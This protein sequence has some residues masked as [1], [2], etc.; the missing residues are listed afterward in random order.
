[1][2]Y[3][4]YKYVFLSDSGGQPSN[5]GA[6]NPGNMGFSQP[7]GNTGFN[8][9]PSNYN[10]PESNFQQPNAAGY[11]NPANGTQSNYQNPTAAPRQPSFTPPAP[12]ASYQ[13]EPV[14]FQQPQAPSKYTN[15]IIDV[16]HYKLLT[17]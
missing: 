9:P 13:P 6:N 2:F 10:Q 8:Q 14:R 16:F 1:V 4:K 3:L 15:N 12:V 5:P 17:N 11:G 7:P